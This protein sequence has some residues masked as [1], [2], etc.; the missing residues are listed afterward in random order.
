MAAMA[1]S[2]SSKKWFLTFNDHEEYQELFIWKNGLRLKLKNGSSS[3]P[4]EKVKVHDEQEK[5]LTVSLN[6]NDCMRPLIACAGG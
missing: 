1:F 5:S 2:I 6:S 4:V 3:G